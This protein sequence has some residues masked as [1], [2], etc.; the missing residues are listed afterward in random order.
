MNLNMGKK[1]NS[2]LLLVMIFISS[3]TEVNAQWTQCKGLGNFTISSFASIGNNLFAGTFDGFVYFSKDS[4]STWTQLA[5]IAQPYHVPNTQLIEGPIIFLFADSTRL[6]AGV[7]GLYNSSIKISTSTDNGLTWT[8][9]DS[10]FIYG[11]NC[12]TSNNETIF[13]GTDNGVFLST[14]NGTS[15]SASNTGLNNA[16]YDS[17]YHHS[18]SVLSIIA[19]GTDI[20]AWTNTDELFHSTDIGKNWSVIKNELLQNISGLA[21]IGNDLFISTVFGGVFLS[22]DNGNNFQAVDTGMTYYSIITLLANGTNLYTATDEG[23]FLSTNKGGNWINISPETQVG[24]HGDA[25]TLAV[26]DSY[27][28]AV[29]YS[30][31]RRPLSEIIT[32]INQKNKLPTSFSL[33]QNFP[34]PFNPTTTINYSIPKSCFISIKVYDILGREVT[35]L[36]S[37]NKPIGNYSVQ[38]NAAKLT[39]GVYFYRMQAGDFVQTKKLVLLK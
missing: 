9:K 20:F 15:W 13:A 28:F 30:F 32:G 27:L 3:I 14:D 18:P 23:I 29:S 25:I 24:P 34:N 26:Y 21:V 35:T 17:I 4:G 10:S 39:S 2:F 36:V 6:I 16:H 12:F 37:E 22:S 33:Q 5:S 8:K 1:H 11:V 31:W 19:K 7:G 38:F